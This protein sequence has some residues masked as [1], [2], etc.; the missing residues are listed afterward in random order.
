MAQDY[1]LKV[2]SCL[3]D[4]D[5]PS[6]RRKKSK[7]HMAVENVH[8][9]ILYKSIQSSLQINTA[10]LKGWSWYCILFMFR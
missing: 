9:Y 7:D 4:H 6:F 8:N 1:L 10:F 3:A 2:E 5:I